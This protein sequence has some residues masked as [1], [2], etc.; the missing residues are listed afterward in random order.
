VSNIVGVEPVIKAVQARLVAD[1]AA[2]IDTLNNSVVD[3]VTVDHPI[4]DGILDYIPL[5][6]E[7]VDAPMIGIDEGRLQWEDDQGFSATGIVDL[8]VVAYVQNADQGA[9]TNLRRR[10]SL[11][12]MRSIL[13][14][15][16]P[17]RLDPA[18]G[19]TFRGSEPGPTGG[20]PWK[21]DDQPPYS[22]LTWT[23]CAFRFKY[24]EG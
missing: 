3:G 8:L 1:L 4:T 23:T 18:W 5:P 16:T 19:I 10:M 20:S 11:A 24:D 14:G 6:G 2:Q 22:Y 17:R 13:E 21:T 12:I 9:L 15:P 7:L